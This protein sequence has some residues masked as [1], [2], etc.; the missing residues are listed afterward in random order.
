MS[1]ALKEKPGPSTKSS[2]NEATKSLKL[3]TVAQQKF[4]SKQVNRVNIWSPL[5][6]WIRPKMWT[7]LII[8]INN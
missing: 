5:K 8:L 6:M 7:L 3:Q 4:A 2:F 1:I